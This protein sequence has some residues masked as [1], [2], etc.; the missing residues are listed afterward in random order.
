[1]S[2]A[3]AELLLESDVYLIAYDWSRDG[4]FLVFTKGSG[5]VPD[6]DL[7]VLPVLGNREPFPF[8][9]SEFHL[10]QPQIA[11]DGRW[12]AYVSNESGSYEVYV[13][14]FPRGDGQWQISNGGGVSPRWSHDGRELFYV[15]P[16]RNL[17]VVAVAGGDGDPLEVGLPKALFETRIYGGGTMGLNRGIYY[18]VT[19]EG[20]RIL[21]RV[22][23]E[24]SRITVLLNWNVELEH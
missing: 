2:T 14:S 3:A 13:R 7:W 24:S 22:A 6:S 18:E 23:P 11:P 5:A 19:E 20:E 12:L 8:L 21:M 17:M 15:A 10:T 16:D 4:R 1:V 9:E